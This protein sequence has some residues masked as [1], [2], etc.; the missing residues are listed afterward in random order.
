MNNYEKALEDA[1]KCVELKGD[2]AKGY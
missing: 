2:W 1:A